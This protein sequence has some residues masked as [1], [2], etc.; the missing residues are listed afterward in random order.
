MDT[1]ERIAVLENVCEA[2]MLGTALLEEGI[3]HV[4]RSHHDLA[5]DGLFQGA[6]GWGHV[7]ADPEHR[8]A[9]LAV[10]EDIR[11]TGGPQEG[12][13]PTEP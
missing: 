3:P 7:E 10:L 9:I 2:E 13:A 1:T 11:A 6:E 4:I 8:E 12:A 5:L